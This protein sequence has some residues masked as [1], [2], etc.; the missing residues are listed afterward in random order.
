MEKTIE[1]DHILTEDKKEDI[2]KIV[3]FNDDN[4]FDHVI[5]IATLHHLQKCDHAK[6]INELL[7][8]VKSGGLICLSVWYPPNIEKMEKN[9]YQVYNKTDIVRYFYIF[10][11]GE[12]DKIIIENNLNMKCEILESNVYKQSQYLYLKKK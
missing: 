8:V 5:C 10:D 7:R 1:Q 4:T 6:A 3:I 11:K 2:R 9:H 12:I